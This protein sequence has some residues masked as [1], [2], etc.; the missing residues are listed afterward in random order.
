M[1]I[2]KII[3]VF[4]IVI[5]FAAFLCS[6]SDL[7][8][9]LDATDDFDWLTNYINLDPTD[10][11][12]YGFKLKNYKPT[13]E[14]VNNLIW[15]QDID[16]F[17]DAI[18]DYNLRQN[19]NILPRFPY[20]FMPFGG[21]C[22][23]RGFDLGFLFR[24]DNLLNTRF[25]LTIATSFAQKGKF[26]LHTNL[27]YPALLNDRM[28]VLGT[29]SFFT[30]YPQYSSHVVSFNGIYDNDEFG[31][32]IINM[33]NKIWG[34]LG[35]DF[36]RQSEYGF[37]FLGGINYRIPFV[38]LESIT[39][40]EFTYKYDDMRVVRTVGKSS[41][42]YAEDELPTF[43]EIKQSNFGFNLRQEFRWNKFKQTATIPEGNYLSAW[44][45]MYLPTTIG[46]PNNEFR[47]KTRIEEKLNKKLWREIAAKGRLLMAANYKI[48]EDFS[49]DPYI[50][51]LADQELTGWFA[52]LANLSLYIPIVNIDMH[53]ALD[54]SLRKD[55]KFIIYWT[56]FADGGFTIENYDNYLEGFIERDLRNRIKNSIVIDNTLTHKY[57][58][59]NN[60]LLPAFT[61]GS[62]I[63][64]YPYFMHFII[65]LD[66]GVNILKAAM[67]SYAAN[68]EKDKVLK[69]IY[70][71]SASECV[72]VVFS[73]STMF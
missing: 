30:S 9:D 38:E 71:Q 7:T 5:N 73:F 65:R 37:I 66:V 53:K 3:Y 16:F 22:Y 57:L 45:K 13:K 55:G 6:Q 67:Y 28:K 35:V 51:G 18:D 2:K 15:H 8:S 42:N 43:E 68:L 19:I 63:E 14:Y 4:F 1:K 23:N 56:L 50:R 21:Y 31:D 44:M 47:F 29:F 25:A 12:F 58:G 41:Y 46:L 27:E 59:S 11:L 10:D 34:K 62:G 24:A 20:V 33:F 48:S 69:G 64:I 49:G 36:Y 61:A 60:Y 52:L 26:W 32:K 17:V 70:N 39:T 40:T 72:E 54:L